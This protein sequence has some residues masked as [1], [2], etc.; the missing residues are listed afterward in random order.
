MTN[1][2]VPARAPADAPPGAGAEAR[3]VRAMGVWAL[4]AS[5]VNITVGGGIFRLPAFVAG[6]LGSSAPLAYVVCAVAMGLIVLCFAEAGSRVALTGGPYAYVEVAFG[7][8]AGFLSGVLL[9]VVGTL[10]LSA[11]ATLFADAVGALVPA[12]GGGAM[13]AALLVATF[14]VLGVVNVLG[15]RQ[16]TAVNVISTVAKLVPLLL[17]LVLGAFAVKA[18]NLSGVATPPDASLARTSVLLIFAFAG[19]ETALVP[20]GEV[21]DVARTIPRA[22]ALAMVGV[23]VLYIGLHL[24][25]QGVLGAALA[26]SKTP[27]ADAAAVALG[28]W[29]RTMMLVGAAVSMFGYV[30]GMTLAVPRAL[31]ALGRDGFLPRGLAAVHPRWHTPYVAIAVQG[32]IVC[33][34]AVSSGFEKLAILANLSTLLLYAACCLAAWELRRRDVRA[35][36]IPFRVPAAGVVPFVAVAAI[37]YMLLSITWQEWAVAGGV[38]VLAAVIYAVSSGARVAARERAA[39]RS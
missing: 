17:L 34:L 32:V 1:D 4:A 35:G 26:G 33:V 20:S 28:P 30:G 19:V 6:Q 39:A 15:V 31:F 2:E 11:V 9:W 21:R 27:L 3:L 23:T 38:L 36:G 29:G 12:L 22:I 14:A 7:P 24:V 37:A 18:S 5:I 8:F 16:G 25:S 13:R 10:A